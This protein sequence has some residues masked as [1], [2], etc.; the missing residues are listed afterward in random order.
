MEKDKSLTTIQDENQEEDSFEFEI[1]DLQDDGT[2]AL[3]TNLA[4]IEQP[5]WEINL[6]ETK[7]TNT[8]WTL[9]FHRTDSATLGLAPGKEM[10]CIFAMLDLLNISEFNQGVRL[11]WHASD[12]DDDTAGRPDP[13]LDLAQAMVSIITF[14]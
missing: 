11:R 6:A 14:S 8:A 3:N 13:E 9:V 12:I 5:H 1:Y 10:T 2:I 4:E 7:I